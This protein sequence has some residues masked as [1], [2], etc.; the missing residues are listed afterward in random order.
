MKITLKFF[1]GIFLVIIIVSSTAGPYFFFHSVEAVLEALRD[2]LKNTAASSA[3]IISGDDVEKIQTIEDAQ[4]PLYRRLQGLL[5]RIM[6]SNADIRYVY[7]MRPKNGKVRFVVDTSEEDTNNNGCIDPDEESAMPGEVYE[8]VTE[9]MLQG[10]VRPSGDK[11]FTTDRWGTFLSGYAPIIDSKGRPVA[12]LGV[13]MLVSK[14]HQKIKRIVTAGIVSLLLALCIGAVLAIFLARQVVKPVKKLKRAMGEVSTGNLDYRIKVNRSD[15]IGE[16]QHGF[17]KMA[18]QIRE[19]ETIKGLFGK[20]VNPEVA[21]YLI[22][23]PLDFSGKGT[24]V[25]ILFVDIREFTKMSEKLPPKMILILLN[26]FFAS[27]VLPIY[28]NKGVVDKY[29]GDCVMAVF[30]VMGAVPD[31]AAAAAKAGLEIIDAVNELNKELAAEGSPTLQVGIGIHTGPVIAGNIGSK[32]RME[33]T[34][35]GD[36]VNVCQ[37]LQKA[38]KHLNV[39]MLLSRQSVATLPTAFAAEKLTTLSVTG[40][41]KKID[42]FTVSITRERLNC[43]VSP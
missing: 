17:N 22:H 24:E 38:T 15:E 13:D 3:E 12:L 28:D 8:N 11:E 27:V 9:G 16:L 35:I 2:Q 37:R 1:L 41:E 18:D 26:R 31:H 39:S 19:K 43:C 33:Y 40:R 4:T 10:F 30:G 5:D 42:V 36:T 7:I 25:T 14:V 34:V 21:E 23:H 20:Y 32:E 6:K 29:I